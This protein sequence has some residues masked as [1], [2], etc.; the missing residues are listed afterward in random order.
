MIVFAAGNNK[1]I[2][3]GLRCYKSALRHLSSLRL[4]PW[5]FESGS[6]Y[7]NRALSHKLQQERS[8]P[9]PRLF[10]QRT[11]RAFKWPLG[12][13]TTPSPVSCNTL[14]GLCSGSDW[15][16]TCSPSLSRAK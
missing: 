14:T 8:Q 10:H 11:L 5:L 7:L 6:R 13:C 16:R 3:R 1:W 12:S 15:V 2:R 4:G 9:L